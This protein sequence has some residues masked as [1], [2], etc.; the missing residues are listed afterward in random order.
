M[1]LAQAAKHE[2]DQ[3]AVW[4]ACLDATPLA[5]GN[6]G[7]ALRALVSRT[8]QTLRTEEI[9]GYCWFETVL[10]CRAH[11]VRAESAM[12]TNLSGGRPEKCLRR[13]WE[14]VEWEGHFEEMKVLEAPRFQK[15]TPPEE[16]CDFS[17]QN[18]ALRSSVHQT[19]GDASGLAGSSRGPTRR[20]VQDLPNKSCW[21]HG[22]GGTTTRKRTQSSSQEGCDDYA[23]KLKGRITPHV[24]F[25]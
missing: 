9:N 2:R 10:L 25:N 5:R 7:H 4:P 12:T 1:L 24:K 11:N 13:H 8:G 22:S 16:R 23:S 15:T 19:D 21:A 18:G 17:K 20:C 3:D 14:R 6:Q